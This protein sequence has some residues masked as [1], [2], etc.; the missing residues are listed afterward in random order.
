MEIIDGV[1]EELDLVEVDELDVRLVEMDEDE[2]E[3]KEE[4]VIGCVLAECEEEICRHLPEQS[5]NQFRRIRNQFKRVLASRKAN[6]NTNMLKQQT[7]RGYLGR[8]VARVFGHFLS[9]ESS[10]TSFRGERERLF[11][12]R[13]REGKLKI[14]FPFYG[15]GT[16]MSPQIA[17]M[18]PCWLHLFFCHYV[19]SL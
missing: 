1:E 15:K 4:A 13:E 16:G 2:K 11:G 18:N 7:T 17:C 12:S 6:I 3:K 14:P 8:Q 10:P 19:S 9:E 5:D